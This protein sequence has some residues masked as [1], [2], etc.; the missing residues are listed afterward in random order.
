MPFFSAI[1]C[2]EIEDLQLESVGILLPVKISLPNSNHKVFIPQKS[3]TE[4][5][6]GAA[7]L[8]PPLP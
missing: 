2:N 7:L 4:M 5:L 1:L 8:P 3:N 6:V